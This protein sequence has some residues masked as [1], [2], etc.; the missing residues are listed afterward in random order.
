M[1][2][3]R[4]VV[5]V[6]CLKKM[7]SIVD[8]L[9]VRKVCVDD[10]AI[11]KRFSYGTVMV[12]LETHRIIDLIPT[13]NTEEVR[14]WLATYPNIEM[15][16]RDGA[17]IYA[18]ASEK[19][20]P[21]VVQVSDRFHI[22]KGLTEAITK[23]IIREFPAR[24]EIP[25]VSINSKEHVKLIDQRNHV[26]R[27][28]FAQTKRAEGMTVNE[29]ALLLHSSVK[30][31]QKYLKLDTD[32]IE[33]K[34]IAREA[35]HWLAMQQKQE[36][37]NTARKMACDGIPIEQ[38]AKEMHHTFKTIQNYLNSSYSVENKHYHARI[39][40]KLAPYE[41][42]V[43]KLR[44]E[45]MTY[46]CIHKIISEKGYDGSVASLRMFIQ[47]E[48]IRCVTAQKEDACSDYQ[49]KEYVQRRSLTQLIYKGLDDVKT[50]SQEQYEQV[51]KSYPVIADLYVTIKEF[52]EIIYSKHEEK[53]DA[54]LVKLEKFNI[55]ELQTYVNG[56]RQDIVAVKNG[57]AMQYNN[58]L[59]EGSVN[60]LKVIKRIMYG[61]NSFEL[62]K[63]KVLL[64]E[65]FRGEIN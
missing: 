41:A 36:E 33:D 21:G 46:P 62:L 56:I 39:P 49:P 5:S 15:I 28:R 27:V 48:R 47:K 9:S 63:A 40:G 58:G 50:I 44:C 60:K 55:P 61:R 11:R 53:L 29:I 17:Q 65:Q 7:P 59:A 4:K 25:A 10:F 13:R 26:D 22:I 38:I 8:N 32:K 3:Y 57:I 24:L 31:I 35:N 14:A 51:L 37:V 34:V 64:H 30:T 20:H 43:I 1:S 2:I 18:N 54:W 16:S 6:F 42:E 12:D 45:G 19:S 52:Y 23:Y